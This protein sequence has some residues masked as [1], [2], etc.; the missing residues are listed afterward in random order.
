MLKPR[1]CE[2]NGEKNK[3]SIKKLKLWETNSV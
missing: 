1:A 3:E 2:R